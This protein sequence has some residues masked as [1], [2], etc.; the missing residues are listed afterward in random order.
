MATMTRQAQAPGDVIPGEDSRPLPAGY[1]RD[2]DQNY[3]EWYYVDSSTGISSWAHPLDERQPSPSGLN[4]SQHDPVHIVP[5]GSSHSTPMPQQMS[6]PSSPMHFINPIL[7]QS[8]IQRPYSSVDQYTGTQ[9]R[10]YPNRPG[11]TRETPLMNYGSL[12]DDLLN[13]PPAGARQNPHGS[14]NRNMP[15]N[16]DPLFSPASQASSA[17]RGPPPDRMDR[18]DRSLPP[19]QQYMQSPQQQ[20]MSMQSPQPNMG[21]QQNLPFQQQSPPGFVESQ[22]LRDVRQ[23]ALLQDFAH[24]WIGKDAP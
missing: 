18:Q 5:P 16:S 1:F 22:A 10:Q 9:Y 13:E 15:Q 19:Q 8:P 3:Q 23:S 14:H 24:Q 7:Q 4:A 11:D 2:F 21:M 20:N 17:P 12:A 6:S